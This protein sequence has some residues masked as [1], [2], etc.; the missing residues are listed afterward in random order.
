MYNSYIYIYYKI[1]DRDG[2]LNC[3]K[4]HYIYCINELKFITFT[5]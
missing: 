4:I 3:I 5:Q 2:G 1:Y